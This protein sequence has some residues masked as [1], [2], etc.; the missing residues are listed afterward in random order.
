MS[1]VKNT[2]LGVV[3]GLVSGATVIAGLEHVGHTIFGT[4]KGLHKD[5][6]YEEAKEIIRAHVREA[7]PLSLLW[8]IG[9]HGCGSFVGGYVAYKFSSS[10]I[11]GRSAGVVGSMFLAGGIANI[12]AI[13][14][15]WWWSVCDVLVYFPTAVVC[16]LP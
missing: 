1:E 8:V 15:P 5:T 7:S 4:P 13:P 6:P 11:I 14:H 10:A 12:A 3:C 16:H 9:A 2:A